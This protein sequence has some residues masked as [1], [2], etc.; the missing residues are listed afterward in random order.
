M[1]GKIDGQSFRIVIQAIEEWQIRNNILDEIYEEERDQIEA[2][3]VDH[4]ID[5]FPQF[6]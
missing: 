3:L 2:R 4:L 1:P 5:I 6:S